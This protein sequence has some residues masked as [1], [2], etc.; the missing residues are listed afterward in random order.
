VDVSGS[1]SAP[2]IMCS[3]R[4]VVVLDD[5]AAHSGAGVRE[6]IAPDGASLLSLRPYSPDL[7]PGSQHRPPTVRSGAPI[8]QLFA[9]LKALLRKTAARTSDAL[10]QAIAAMRPAECAN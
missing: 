2:G 7:A 8:E 10:W 4:D 9:R 5:L 6:T 3:G 1:G